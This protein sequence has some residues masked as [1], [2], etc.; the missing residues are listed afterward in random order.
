M[1]LEEELLREGLSVRRLPEN[2]DPT[3]MFL[4]EHEIQ[5]VIPSVSLRCIENLT[6]LPSGLMFHGTKVLPIS[7][8]YPE[9]ADAWMGYLSRLKVFIKNYLLRHPRRIQKEV[10]WV[11][12]SWS[13]G[14]FHWMTDVL[15]RLLVLGKRVECATLLLPGDYR[16]K[17]YVVSSLRPFIIGDIEFLDEPSRFRMVWI[18]THT[19]PTGSYREELIRALRG[20]FAEYYAPIQNG[21]NDEKVYI[22]RGKAGIR[23]ILNEDE[24]IKVFDQYGFSTM[25]F[26]DITFEQQVRISLGAKYLVSNHGAGLTNML[27]MKSGCSVLELRKKG[28]SHNNCYFSLASAVGLKYYYQQ[29]VSDNPDEDAHSANLIVDCDALKTNIERMLSSDGVVSAKMR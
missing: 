28:D 19:A 10:F 16:K 3:D 8:P 6:I 11:T 13:Y 4:F 25:H 14:Y 29:C 5:R 18:P 23:K 12:D 17:E 9:Y 24:C 26:E 2:L 21:G 22:S 15:P 7:F 1:I 20:L 27:F